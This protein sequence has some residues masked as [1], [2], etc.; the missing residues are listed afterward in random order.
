M[1][2]L[3]FLGQGLGRLDFTPLPG[4]EDRCD[5]TPPPA[6]TG[7]MHALGPPPSG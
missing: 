1:Q 7:P 2:I 3:Q 4:I 5:R 6:P